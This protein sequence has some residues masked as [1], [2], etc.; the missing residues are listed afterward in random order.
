MVLS[1]QY[2]PKKMSS[3]CL[4]VCTEVTKIVAVKNNQHMQ[5]TLQGKAELDRCARLLGRY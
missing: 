5:S 3:L 1:R 2:Q 4:F